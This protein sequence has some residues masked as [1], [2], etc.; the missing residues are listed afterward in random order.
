M[1]LEINERIQQYKD[2]SETVDR[3]ERLYGTFGDKFDIEVERTS[4]EIRRLDIFFKEKKTDVQQMLSVTRDMETLEAS[5][6]SNLSSASSYGLSSCNMGLPGTSFYRGLLMRP[7][8]FLQNTVERFQNKLRECGKWLDEN[9]QLILMDT[10]GPSSSFSSLPWAI[11]DTMSSTHEFFVYV[12]G[13]VE[14]LHE[15]VESLK[16][17]FLLGWQQQGQRGNPFFEADR[18]EAARQENAARRT[19]NFSSTT[20]QPNPIS[21]SFPNPAML[22]QSVGNFLASFSCQYEMF[23]SPTPSIPASG[24]PYFPPSNP[25]APM[26]STSQ[27]GFTQNPAMSGGASSSFAPIS[28]AGSPLSFAIG[29]AGSARPGPASTRV[30][31]RLRDRRRRR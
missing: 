8:P 27:S 12:A 21:G 22:Q 1:F 9:E 24:T 13:K 5:I 20:E 2:E 16:K 10:F 15:M 18:Q 3:C 25:T 7:T 23:S 17:N 19:L 6:S 4:Q 11:K 14:K 28:L 26:D 31:P 30:S 29:A